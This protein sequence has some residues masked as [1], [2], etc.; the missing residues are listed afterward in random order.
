MLAD[1][2]AAISKYWT[3][4]YVKLFAKRGPEYAAEGKQRVRKHEENLLDVTDMN[5]TGTQVIVQYRYVD[6]S[7]WADKAG[8]PISN[9]SND[10]TEW[11]LT[12]DKKKAGW[13]VSRL[14][15]GDEAYK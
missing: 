2:Q 10:E 6:K 15:A 12:L 5:S 1:D 4:E 13:V 9:P 3:P 11:Q 8:K 14:I 7:F